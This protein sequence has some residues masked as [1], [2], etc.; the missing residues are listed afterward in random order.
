MAKRASP[1]FWRSGRRGSRVAEA[2]G[3]ARPGSVTPRRDTRCVDQ[4]PGPSI[5]HVD[6]DAFYASVEQLRRPELRGKPIAVGGG[7]IL[8]ASYEARRFGVRSAMPL[9]QARKLCPRLIVVEGSYGDYLGLSNEVFEVCRRYTPRVEQISIDEAFL[10]VS[11]AH[12]LFGSG[13]RIASA[14][15]RDILAEVE[16]PISAGVAGTKFL[17]KIASRVAKP[18]GLV[19]VALGDELGFL[20]PL[21]VD[22]LW[23]VGPATRA[24]LETLGIQTVGDLADTPQRALQSRLGP[25]AGRH[26]HSLAWNRDARSVQTDRSARSVGAQRAF[27]GDVRDRG[28]WRQVVRAIA[29]RVGSRLRHKRRAG[30]TLSVRVR[31]NDRQAVS[32]STTLAAPVNSTDALFSVALELVDRAVADAAKGRGLSLIGLSVSKLVVAPHLQLELPLGAAVGGGAR[33]AGSELALGRS[34]LDAAVDGVRDKFGKA[35]VVAGST[36]TRP[37]MVPDEFGELAVPAYER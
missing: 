14:I 27:G 20:H 33:R 7:V 32:R 10:D 34:L 9:G 13:A 26:L 21:P 22:I 28:V 24:R 3:P 15:R 1:H 11:G 17:A 35:A 12:H 19:E 4:Q 18:D 31:F 6:L 5:I 25:S 23:G 8:A 36:M 37:G 30:R 29:D 2:A 16:L